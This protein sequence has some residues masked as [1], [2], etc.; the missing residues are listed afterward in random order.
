MPALGIFSRTFDGPNLG[1]VL[2]RAAAHGFR[3]LHF[4]FKSAG[5]PTLPPD[6]TVELCRSVGQEFEGRGLQMAGASATYNVIHPDRERRDRE[7]EL[8]CRLI[9]LAPQLGTRFVS[10]STGTRDPNGLWRAHPANREPAAWSDMIA[11]LNRLLSA[12]RTARV[13]LGIEAEQGNVVSS[14]RLARR[15]L[16]ELADSHLA[17]ILDAANLISAATAGQQRAI[18]TEAF[19]L[20]GRD[21]AFFHAKDLGPEGVVAAGR[22]LLDYSFYFE[23]IA[24]NRSDTSVIVHEVAQ[25]DVD[26]ARDFLLAKA[27]EA[28]LQLA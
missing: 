17:I 13:T 1:A 18:L 5:L 9:S 23:L 2:D 22:G 20:L 8:A 14:A 6:L 24:R 26:R 21:V 3:L 12:A 10:L 19:E 28:G 16:D 4:N 11:T 15:L 27:H 25:D 7:T